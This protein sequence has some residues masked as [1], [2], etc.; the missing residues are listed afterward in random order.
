MVRN[1][2]RP[3]QVSYECTVNLKKVTFG[4]NFK[5]R[6]PRAMREIRS[7]VE[8]L[9]FADEIHIDPAVNTYVWSKGVR[10]VPRHVR[11][12]V[13]RMRSEETDQLIA[14]VKHV[15][16]DTFKG[17]QT[18]K[19]LMPRPSQAPLFTGHDYYLSRTAKS[20]C[21]SV[22]S[23]NAMGLDEPQPFI[24]H[25]TLVSQSDFKYNY[26]QYCSC[27]N[28]FFK[29]LEDTLLFFEFENDR[30][31]HT[32]NLKAP[33][34][35][36]NHIILHDRYVFRERS[37]FVSIHSLHDDTCIEVPGI[38]CR[39][40]IA[41]QNSYYPMILKDDLISL[42]YLD[43]NGQV[44]MEEVFHPLL[45]N[46]GKTNSGTIRLL[47]HERYRDVILHD[48]RAFF[49]AESVRGAPY[50]V[51][52]YQNLMQKVT[53][54][55]PKN[56]RGAFFID[57]ALCFIQSLYRSLYCVSEHGFHLDSTFTN[58]INIFSD[59]N[60]QLFK[61][62]SDPGAVYRIDAQMTDRETMFTLTNDMKI[63]TLDLD[64]D[65]KPAFKTGSSLLFFD[66]IRGFVAVFLGSKFTG[67]GKKRMFPLTG[68]YFVEMSDDTL[69]AINV[70]TGI[71]MHSTVVPSTSS[72]II[73]AYSNRNCLL[74]HTTEEIITRHEVLGFS[75][76]NSV[77]LVEDVGYIFAEIA[78]ISHSFFI[79]F[80][81][82][83]EIIGRVDVPFK[84]SEYFP[85]INPYNTKS[86]LM[87]DHYDYA[88]YYIQLE[89]DIDSYMA[90]DQT[91]NYVEFD[92]PLPD[93]MDCIFFADENMFI[94]GGSLLT[95]DD[96]KE[97]ICDL[98]QCFPYP[99]FLSP[100]YRVFSSP[101]KYEFF[102]INLQ[103]KDY[104]ITGKRIWY[105]LE[106]HILDMEDFNLNLIELLQSTKVVCY[107][108]FIEVANF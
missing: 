57:H 100:E 9:T 51:D 33:S 11:I 47:N 65:F 66:F 35:M 5:K 56:L 80:D 103:V 75:M 16:V 67:E 1:T 88:F 53:D 58:F 28:L 46:I 106:D 60:G 4:R 38:L 82:N 81:E 43:S 48:G 84:P 19:H 108:D 55:L 98:N 83:G 73:D 104:M 32:H 72:K 79:Q 30:F 90:Y 6:A 14:V 21:Y 99:F 8:K 13:E 50:I 96:D 24:I 40:A 63:S 44:N 54:W 23:L 39:N 74:A 20:G 49:V 7:F 18:T 93:D 77:R 27:S 17:K 70:E 22:I 102:M 64:V 86:V 34:T 25:S 105:D 91:G 97:D 71:T 94:S 37:E 29:R 69:K 3:D 59:R 76:I 2:S 87:D 42:L 45:K 41:L 85:I 31:I 89:F 61:V 107:E 78:D 52:E 62:M 36:I 15:P 26:L 12:A 68:S 10:N 101:N 95:Y 92:L